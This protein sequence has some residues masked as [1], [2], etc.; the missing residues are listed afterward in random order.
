MGKRLFA[1]FLS[2]LLAKWVCAETLVCFTDDKLKA[3][4][5][6]ELWIADPTPEDMLGLTR[7]Y[8]G[9]DGIIDLTGLEYATNLESLELPNNNIRDVTA[10]SGLTNLRVLSLRSNEISDVSSL[11]GLSS[12]QDVDLFDNQVSDISAF[13]GLANIEKLN[14]QRN[15][16]GS[17]SSLS[18][19][20]RLRTLD[21]HRNQVSDVCPLVTLPCLEWLDLRINPLS[22]ETYDVCIPQ[23][24]QNRPGMWLAY[25]PSTQRRLALSSTAGGS[26]INPGEGE[27]TWEHGEVVWLLA[28][29]EP[30]FLFANWSGSYFEP[31]NSMFLTMDDNFE[32]RANFVCVGDVIYVNNS[33]LQGVD[34][35]SA[36]QSDSPENGTPDH[37]FDQIQEAIEVAAEGASIIVYPGLYRERIDFLGKS[38]RVMGMEVNEPNGA[39]WPVIDGGGADTVVRFGAGEDSNSML[40]GFT[41]TGGRAQSTGA[42]Q[43]IGSSPTIANCLIVGN[44]ATDPNGAAVLCTDS[45]AAFI[46]CVIA[47]NHAGNNGAGLSLRESRAVV[48]NSIIWANAPTGIVKEGGDPYVRFSDIAG[49]WPGRGNVDT[50][51]LFAKAGYWVDRN[52]PDVIVGPAN[53]DAVWIMGDYHLKSRAG[54]WDP[55]VDLWVQDRRSSPCIDAGDPRSWVD[56]EP[57]PNGGIINMGAYGGTAQACKSY[58]P[59][60]ARGWGGGR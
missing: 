55:A 33:A 28:E 4:V 49:G 37:P 56:Q 29:A 16:V 26:V 36:S 38:I 21:L 53:P 5:E 50:D 58:V 42:I 51:P 32:M 23:M 52:H 60:A 6:A 8:A 48:A 9:D 40:I 19:L 39:T 17:V 54:R 1:F 3:A 20:L 22:Q 44:R 13:S 10:L 57:F 43:C 2:L 7:L 11:S 25:Y 31:R 14:L 27:F 12:L 34:A 18:G 24:E 15:E 46:N 41:I 30:G 59:L 47:D 45:Q 35:A